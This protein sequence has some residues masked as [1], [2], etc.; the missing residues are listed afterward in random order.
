MLLRVTAKTTKSKAVLIAIFFRFLNFL[1]IM[2]TNLQGEGE[3]LNTLRKCTG[4]AS[5]NTI[6]QRHT[7]V[8]GSAALHCINGE[9][10][11]QWKMAKFDL[12]HIRDPFTNR[13]KLEL[14][15]HVIEATLC[16]GGLQSKIKTT[17]TVFNKT[18]CIA[19]QDN[20]QVNT[21]SV[22]CI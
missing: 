19:K 20:V 2:P 22:Q 4:V 6:S 8:R 5:F 3:H 11:G 13:H 15:N 21:E 9:S 7:G 14:L 17:V 16:H 1:S 10:S 12:A 18:T